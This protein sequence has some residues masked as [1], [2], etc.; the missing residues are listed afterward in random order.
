MY[1][2]PKQITCLGNVTVSAGARTALSTLTI[3]DR[4]DQILIQCTTGTFYFSDSPGLPTVLSTDGI[5]VPA[6]ATFLYV[7]DRTN[8]YFLGSATLHFYATR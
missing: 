1:Y 2:A 6:G 5:A 4:C 3:P 8:F 7:G